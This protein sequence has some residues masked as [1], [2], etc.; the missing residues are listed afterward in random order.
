MADSRGK[1]EFLANTLL[2]E[3]D[4]EFK[5]VLGSEK[6]FNEAALMKQ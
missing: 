3:D 6:G 5:C 1:K 2:A 4:G